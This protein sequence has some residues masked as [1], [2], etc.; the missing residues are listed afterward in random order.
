MFLFPFTL[1]GYDRGDSFLLDFEPNEISFGSKSKGKLS[2]R[3]YPM[4]MEIEFSQ[5]IRGGKRHISSSRS[6]PQKIYKVN[7]Y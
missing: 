2:P 7:P 5:C 6:T 3:A 1:N 4:E